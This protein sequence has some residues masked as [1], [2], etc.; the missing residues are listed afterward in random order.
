M[1]ANSSLVVYTRLSPN[2]SGPRT[3]AIDRITPHC[4]A[5]LATCESLGAMFSKPERKASCN[6]CIDKD[7]RIGLIVPEDHRS[8][9]S[10]SGANDQRAVTIE[11]ASTNQDPYEMSAWVW[12]NLID[13]C[14]DI[15]K[16]HRK[17]RLIWIDDKTKALNY[18]PESDE[19]ILTVHRWF[20]NKACPGDWLY[21][22]LGKLAEIVTQRIGGSPTKVDKFKVQAGAFRNKERAAALQEQLSYR[23]YKSILTYSTSDFLYRVQVGAFNSKKNAEKLINELKIKGFNA[24]IV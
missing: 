24:V 23:G 3:H 7:G 5:G 12:D 15:C 4:T 8:W 6:Y 19:M 9:C 21:S 13:L 22:R 1:M 2:E 20:K 17:N 10:S 16:R 18:V 14:V 11:C